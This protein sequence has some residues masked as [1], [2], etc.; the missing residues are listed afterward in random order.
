MRLHRVRLRK[1]LARHHH[2]VWVWI[3]RRKNK[4]AIDPKHPHAPKNHPLPSGHVH[5]K[6]KKTDPFPAHVVYWCHLSLAYAGKMTYTENWSL[7]K[8]FFARAIGKFLGALADCSQFVAAILH[9]LGVKCVTDTDYTGSLLQ[10]GRPILH[11]QPGCVAVW[12]PGTGDHTAFVTEK[13]GNGDWY[14]VGFGHQGAPDRNTLSGLNAYFASIGH[15]GVRFL[16]FEG[17]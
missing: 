2:P 3:R 9:W 7:R 4:P 13:V 1:L 6:P 15:P 12:G 16:D 10:K 14:V 5:H 8:R 17:R 11:P